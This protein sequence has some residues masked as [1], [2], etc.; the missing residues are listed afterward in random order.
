MRGR[1][2]TKLLILPCTEKRQ[3]GGFEGLLAL[4]EERGI[5]V[6]WMKA[7]MEWESGGVSVRCLHPAA[8]FQGEDNNAAS[9]VLL[10]TR[11]AAVT[12]PCAAIRHL[13]T[14]AVSLPHIQKSD[15]KPAPAIC[16]Q[17]QNRSAQTMQPEAVS[18]AAF[19]EAFGREADQRLGR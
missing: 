4:A 11:A 3:N 17:K 9:Q 6:L 13:Q 19:P 16:R 18:L 5:P 8:D 7:G 10:H 2:K 15:A 12:E 1:I 14:D